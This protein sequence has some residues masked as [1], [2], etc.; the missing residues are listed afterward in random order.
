MIKKIIKTVASVSLACLVGAS[1]CILTFATEYMGDVNN[2]GNVNSTDALQILQYSIELEGIEINEKKADI[3]GDKVI[4]SLDALQVLNIS[5]G[6]ADKIELPDSEPSE[7]A[8]LDYD[9][10]ETV[11][12]YNSALKKAYANENV[13]IKKTVGF[14]SIKLEKFSPTSLKSAVQGLIDDYTKPSTK[15]QTFNANAAAA[16]KFLV[17]TALESDGAKAATVEATKQGYKITITLVDEKVNYKTAPKYNT[18]ASLPITG[19][20]DLVKEYGITVKSSQLDYTGTIITAEIDSDGNLISLNHTMPLKIQAK[21]N[22]SIFTVDGQGSG[23]YL[24]NAN[25]SY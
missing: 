17:P 14:D 15:I 24:L 7:K 2:D 1:T 12:Y 18:Q 25:F 4:N 21:G 9:K 20:A 11:E 3:N 13:T 5:I 10:A 23:K 8:P 19:I 22:Y 6:L 16:E